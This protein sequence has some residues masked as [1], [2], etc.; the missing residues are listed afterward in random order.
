MDNFDKLFQN[1]LGEISENDFEFKDSSWER[2][3][4]GWNEETETSRK[5]VPLVWAKRNVAAAAIILLLLTSNVFFAQQFLGT[6]MDMK[7]LTSTIEELRGDI[8]SCQENSETYNNAVASLETKVE[9][10]S[11][12]IEEQ[13]ELR[14][15]NNSNQNRTGFFPMFPTQNGVVTNNSTS[16]GN[17]NLNNNPNVNPN[18]NL[19]GGN[20]PNE[21]NNVTNNS[22]EIVNNQSTNNTTVDN[23][24]TEEN[25]SNSA[26]NDNTEIVNNTTSNTSESGTNE[27]SKSIDELNKLLIT[28]NENRANKNVT[29][30]KH[31]VPKIENEYKPDFGTKLNMFAEDAKP[32]AYQVGVNSM[33]SY[34]PAL[35]ENT[36]TGFVLV[37]MTM[38]NT[39][40]IANATFFKRLRVQVGANYWGQ[41]L[42]DED[43]ANMSNAFLVNLSAYPTIEPNN[44]SD[45]ISKIE[46]KTY[47]FDFPVNAQLLLRPN[48][49]LNP[50]IGFG[51]VGRYYNNYKQE[52]YFID[53]NN[54]YEYELKNEGQPKSFSFGILQ[55]QFGIDYSITDN[56]LVNAEL[57]LN[58]IDAFQSQE[59]GVP[60]DWQ[61][62]VSLGVKY[63]F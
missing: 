22:G 53:N 11:K 37:P 9:E 30:K 8:V 18:V 20:I 60:H 24:T 12:V 44:S 51:I 29:I 55:S 36:D 23:N 28:L 38:N 32:S 13:T 41:I 4:N 54:G 2:F 40:I 33:F 46:I 56:W 59:F 62:G 17:G 48:S 19:N 61:Y 52:Y 1:K 35:N 39:G 21:S 34:L 31:P 10:Q 47:G 43:Y 7:K 3:Q 6:R 45:E 5:F 58:Y 57:N 50:Y 49:K 27:I 15:N 16:N 14:N 26:T 63:E 25:P 42:N